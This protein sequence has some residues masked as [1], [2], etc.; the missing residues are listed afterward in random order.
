MAHRKTK[1][2]PH[3]DW[4]QDPQ[5]QSA[6]KLRMPDRS[7]EFLREFMPD[8]SWVLVAIPP[9]GG[10]TETRTFEPSQEPEL[11]QW[12]VRQ[13]AAYRN[14]YFLVGQTK[15]SVAVIAKPS[16]AAMGYTWFAWADLDPPKT[17]DQGDARAVQVAKSEIIKRLAA[18]PLKPAF[19]I[20]SGGGLQPLWALKDAFEFPNEAAIA[21]FEK[22]NKALAK[23]LGGDACH[24]IDRVMRLPGTVNFPNAKKRKQGRHTTVAR[25]LRSNPEAEYTFE[26]IAASVAPYVEQE[27]AANG[28]AAFEDIGTEEGDKIYE[29]LPQSLQ[30]KL[31]FEDEGDR[32]KHVH[33]VLLSLC[34]EGLTN[35]EIL[36]VSA[37]RAFRRKFSKLAYMKRE[38]R[39][40]RA[41][42]K[43]KGSKINGQ[44]GDDFEPIAEAA[45]RWTDL[46]NARRLVRLHG[47][48][49]R[50]VPEWGRWLAWA[51]HTWQ[52]DATGGVTR[53]AKQTI[54]SLHAEAAGLRDEAR[55]T[56]LRKFAIKCEAA[57]RIQGMIELA[58]TELPVILAAEAIDGDPWLAG[59]KNGVIELKTRTFRPGRRED[60]I[61]R[62][63]GVDYDPGARCPRWLE[64]LAR[65][66]ARDAELIAY[67]ARAV[68]YS[69]TGRTIEEVIFIL[70]GLGANGKTT[71]REVIFALLG[72]Y[73]L[74]SNA[75]LLMTR[76][77]AGGATPEVAALHG[78]RFV[79][80]NETAEGD[81]LN[82]A[83]VK[84]VTGTDKIA[85]RMLHENYVTFG[86]THKTWITTNHRPIVRGTDEG[87]WRRL[88][89][90]PFTETIPFKERDRDFR[91]KHLM[92]ELAGILN[93]ALD[94]L[95]DYLRQGLNPPE[96]V[97]ASI[98]DYQDDMDVIGQWLAARTVSDASAKIRT[99]VLHSD[100]AKWSQ[101][102]IG[103]QRTPK[104]FG[105]ALMNRGFKTSKGA[106][107]A[108]MIKGL[109]LR[110]D[111]GLFRSD[112]A[113]ELAPL[114]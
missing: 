66:M 11:V 53:L 74:A 60:N 94:G 17:I 51:G 63:L 77:N 39:K 79:A 55:R 2:T 26:E 52:R 46:G 111:S 83:R 37:G 5:T 49:L 110:N 45:E 30:E 40:A 29:R 89:L 43:R 3:Y 18:F 99:A 35:A 102:E 24:N 87:I 31:D 61:T 82:E 101:D 20:D 6:L 88:Q 62:V 93:W 32:R 70:Y 68:G 57:A 108:R 73:A 98:A 36:E 71:F 107:G 15:P 23:A 33:H 65:I 28:E 8:G 56:E 90:I 80:V 9:D 7:I 19:L 34:E 104:A 113:D 96:R 84:F 97:K 14:I 10:A 42:W 76:K 69:L 50:Y 85:G 48:N 64:F 112:P 95:Q 103:W 109:R 67:L 27:A 100:Y 21:E 4:S 105:R 16:K 59:V 41:E 25:L 72:D 92:P 75:D 54:E 106:Q 81:F 12:I 1:S 22:I 47:E 58:K 86:P 91:Q 44:A 13:Q 78:A 114:H 38:I